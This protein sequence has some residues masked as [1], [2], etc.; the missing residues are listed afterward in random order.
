MLIVVAWRGKRSLSREEPVE[1][2]SRTR[3][4]NYRCGGRYGVRACGGAVGDCLV[5]L[6]TV[7]WKYIHQAVPRG[8]RPMSLPA[9]PSPGAMYVVL[10]WSEP[11]HAS[12]GT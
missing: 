11:C 8:V 2:L 4:E 1:N 10:C 5:Y 9:P 7:I 6:L 12:L 3:G